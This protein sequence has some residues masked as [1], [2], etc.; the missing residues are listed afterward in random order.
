MSREL[1]VP[2]GGVE[3]RV[4]ADD[5]GRITDVFLLGGW[6]NAREVLSLTLIAAL[7]EGA[8]EVVA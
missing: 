5:A 3:F 1:I 4:C 6:W 8:L 2:C 7:E